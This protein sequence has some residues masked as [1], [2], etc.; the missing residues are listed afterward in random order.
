MAR[1]IH[2]R[3][4]FGIALALAV[5]GAA[6]FPSASGALPSDT[7]IFS[8]GFENGLGAWQINTRVNGSVTTE[9]GMGV[10]GSTGAHLVVADVAGSMAYIKKTLP[11][12]VY[13]LSARGK[14]KVLS[15]G[16]DIAAGYSAG[17]VPFLR[18]F[19]ATG[20]RLVGLYR[21]NGN[22]GGNTKLYAQHSG[23][24]WR[25]GANMKLDTWYDLELRATVAG[26]GQGLVEVYVNG[27]RQYAT[28]TAT[29]GIDPI[30]S[31][32]LHNEHPNQVG[33]LAAD[34][35]RLATFPA[36]P[37][38]NPCAPGTPLPS[39]DLPGT[40]VLADGFESFGFSSWTQSEQKGDGA[41]RIL[42]GDSHTG[43]CAGL[44]HVTSSS[45]SKAF[46]SKNLPTG[47]ST[48]AADGWFRVDHEGGAGSN[49]PFFRMFNGTTRVAD[50]YRENASG[51]L[52]LRTVNA[53]GGVAYQSLG[54]TV[55]LGTWHH[56]Q[57]LMTVAGTGSSLEIRL[58]DQVIRAGA[59]S[60]GAAGLTRAQVG[61]E[62]FAQ[63]MDLVVDDVV[64]KAS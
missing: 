23:T 60:L 21:I 57:A 64:F 6:A 12:P 46:L 29:N 15:A 8:D 4:W 20:E 30:A 24:F 28:N 14:F 18:F 38:A 40:G 39:N 22:C 16:C 53:S 36:A 52:F 43:T 7:E 27:Q 48:V 49:V 17:S 55:A 37:P 10:N 44:L 54:R 59:V 9:P 3:R 33:D 63:V 42:T 1:D 5:L 41:V 25:T 11:E 56:I 58:D 50:I 13:A 62:H 51:R 19:D 35:I 61:A 26:P 47:T 45:G 31:V 34:D 2:W 32:N